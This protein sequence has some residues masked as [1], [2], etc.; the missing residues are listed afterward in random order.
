LA[1]GRFLDAASVGFKT[2]TQNEP[3]RRI[4]VSY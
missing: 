4:V 2:M 1:V 3:D